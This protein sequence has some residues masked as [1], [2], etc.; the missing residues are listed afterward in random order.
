MYAFWFSLQTASYHW[1]KSVGSP[2]GKKFFSEVPMAT[3]WIQIWSHI[4][5]T[6]QCWYCIFLELWGQLCGTIGRL[7]APFCLMCVLWELDVH[8]STLLKI[9]SMLF[10]GMLHWLLLQSDIETSITCSI[11]KPGYCLWDSLPLEAHLVPTLHSFRHKEQ[12]SVFTQ[13][14]NKGVSF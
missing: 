11:S 10:Q 6:G 14:F 12:T 1:A 3:R 8:T 5:C 9:C 2:L 4:F 7:Q 13:T